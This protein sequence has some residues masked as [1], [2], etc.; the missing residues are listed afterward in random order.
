MNTKL[1]FSKESDNWTTPLNIYEKYMGR[2]YFDPCPVNPD[3]DGLI[4]DWPELCFVNPPYS[5]IRL[6][7]EKAISEVDKGN[8]EKAVFLVPAR[9]DV[10]WFHDLVYNQY[11]IQF[12][13][14]RLKFSGSSDN[15]PFPSMFIW[16]KR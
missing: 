11:D 2:R 1:F 5:K 8:C 14:G 13:K 12:I 4:I 7:L 10:R 3:F 16:V 6:W 9:T 15:A